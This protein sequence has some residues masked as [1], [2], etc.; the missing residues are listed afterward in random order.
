MTRLATIFS[1]L[2]VSV[3]STEVM[4]NAVNLVWYCYDYDYEPIQLHYYTGLEV[5]TNLTEWTVVAGFPAQT[6][7]RVSMPR[8]DMMFFRVWM[9][10]TNRF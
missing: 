3:F 7:N 6:T 5:S 2:C 4:Q 1:L 10:E 8:E 9:S